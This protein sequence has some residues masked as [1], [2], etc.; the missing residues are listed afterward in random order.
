[1]VVHYIKSPQ[2]KNCVITSI[3]IEKAFNKIQHQF[4]IKILSVNED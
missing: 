2:K 1:M 4:M 3:D